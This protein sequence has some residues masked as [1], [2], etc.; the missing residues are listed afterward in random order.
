MKLLA[1][2]RVLKKLTLVIFISAALMG[3]GWWWYNRDLSIYARGYSEEAFRQVAVGMEK[4]RVYALLGPPLSI[5]EA[6]LP[7]SWSYDPSAKEKR[8][9]RTTHNL[10][11]PPNRV[12]FD[13]SAR[14][15]KVSGPKL[16]E[17]KAGMS[18]AQ[19]IN[20]AGIP[21]RVAPQRHEL[22]HYSAPS[23]I[24]LYR[25]RIIGVDQVG[26]VTR[27]TTYDMHD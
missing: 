22:L 23:G 5:D 2:R 19:V 10:F 7:E 26:L 18:K 1:N 13:R 20:I 24:G 8:G 3:T 9:V 21:K 17:V 16:S 4:Q 11:E 27:V 6:R 25:A 14:V 15:A 12:E